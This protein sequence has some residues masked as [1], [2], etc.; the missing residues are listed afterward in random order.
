MSPHT[1]VFVSAQF[2]SKERA[3]CEQGARRLCACHAERE[4]G[5]DLETH[6]GENGQI[7]ETEEEM[8][9]RSQGQE[10]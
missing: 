4:G 6:G 10:P 7:V 2:E 8:A 3:V 5:S 1:C 9:L